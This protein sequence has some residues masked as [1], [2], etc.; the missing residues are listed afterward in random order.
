MPLPAST[1]ESGALEDIEGVENKRRGS[2]KKLVFQVFF[3]DNISS[4]TM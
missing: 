1:W 4:R 2:E 3:K